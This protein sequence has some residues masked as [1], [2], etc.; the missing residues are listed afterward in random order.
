[1]IEVNGLQIN[2]VATSDCLKTS[3]LVDILFI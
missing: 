3:K 2:M 1:M